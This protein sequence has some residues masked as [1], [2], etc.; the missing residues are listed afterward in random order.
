MEQEQISRLLD[1]YLAGNCTPE[2]EQA[3]HNWL[4]SRP[5]QDQRWK[6]MSGA[7]QQAYLA[8]LFRDV[9]RT[10]G[11]D[12][13][14]HAQ[15]FAAG[16]EQPK[17]GTGQALATGTHNE[18]PQTGSGQAHVAA[19]N[20]QPDATIIRL[21][22]RRRSLRLTL[23]IAAAVIVLMGGTLLYLFRNSLLPAQMH[24][25]ATAHRET[26]RV[27]LPDSSVVV[28][29]S[30]SKL[31]YADNWK[32]RKV[33]L[34]GEAYFE[35]QASPEHPFVIRSGEVQTRVLGTS[36]NISAYP[37]DKR[38]SVGV[39]TGKV[40]LSKIS[41][42]GRILVNPGEMAVYDREKDHIS[43][44][45]TEEKVMVE[46]KEIAV[47]DKRKNHIVHSVEKDTAYNAWMEGKLNFYRTPLSDVAA[48]LERVFPI[49]ITISNNYEN[50]CEINGRFH[51]NQSPAE[52]L[53]IICKSINAECTIEGN[54]AVIKN[55]HPCY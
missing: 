44:A 27:I 24:T 43:H 50:E 34:E 11:E 5:Q 16:S 32:E 52:I 51:V 19:G 33:T 31:S 9:R 22:S 6:E 48:A 28:L 13:N 37:Q 4:E 21:P 36:F 3:V 42:D 10:I 41:A 47:F 29:N 7:A 17:A 54:E 49:N 14:V 25:I 55:D 53:T 12:G 30:N 20:E 45:G 39:M 1:K 46:S 38:I 8:E 15:R 40:E 2:E 18:R 35:V 26:K 23:R